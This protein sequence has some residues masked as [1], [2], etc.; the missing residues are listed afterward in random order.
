VHVARWRGE[1]AN[2]LTVFV[3]VRASS[4]EGAAKMFEGHPHITILPCDAVDVMPL[5]SEPDT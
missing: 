2:E 4:H 1:R 5:L 3:V